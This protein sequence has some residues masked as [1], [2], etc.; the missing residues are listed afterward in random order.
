MSDLQTVIKKTKTC[1]TGTKKLRFVKHE[2]VVSGPGL[3]CALF[4]IPGWSKLREEAT[5]LLVQT[6]IMFLFSFVRAE[7]KPEH[8]CKR[9]EE[10][11]ALPFPGS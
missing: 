4:A 2:I 11:I 6:S 5:N 8:C 7:T 3:L 9:E 10:V 1:K